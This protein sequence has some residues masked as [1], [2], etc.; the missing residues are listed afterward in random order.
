MFGRFQCMHSYVLVAKP[1]YKNPNR[2]LGQMQWMHLN[3]GPTEEEKKHST[4]KT[5]LAFL[6][7]SN[8]KNGNS[9]QITNG[10]W[11]RH[12]NIIRGTNHLRIKINGGPTATESRPNSRREDLN[13]EAEEIDDKKKHAYRNQINYTNSIRL[14]TANSRSS[15]IRDA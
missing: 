3:D 4:S 2:P 1:S 7:S 14:S 5:V 8:S 15:S 9:F 10:W 13:A 11:L 6:N 12:K